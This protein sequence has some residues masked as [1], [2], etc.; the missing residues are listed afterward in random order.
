VTDWE[1]LTSKGAWMN[2]A[3]DVT[4]LANVTTL[5]DGA[6]TM[7]ESFMTAL[8]DCTKDNCYVYSYQLFIC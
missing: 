5:A 2:T 6:P 8:N 4:S 1:A 7:Y 3:N